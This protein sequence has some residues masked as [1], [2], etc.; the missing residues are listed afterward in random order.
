MNG[1]RVSHV[2]ADSPPSCATIPALLP[3]APIK[4]KPG[5]IKNVS[6]QK[7]ENNHKKQIPFV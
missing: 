1:A 3:F 5:G 6:E 4:N 2:P 7:S